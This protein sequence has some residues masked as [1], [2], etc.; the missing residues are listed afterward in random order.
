MPRGD[1]LRHGVQRDGDPVPLAG[2]ERSGFVVVTSPSRL[3]LDQAAYFHGRLRES[4]MPFVAF[5]AN[6]VH[7]EPGGG[8]ARRAAGRLDE[9]LVRA[10][11]EV[12]R[13]QQRLA[14][15]DARALARLEADTR[16]PLLQVPELEADVHD[17]RGLLTIGE[18]MLGQEPVSG[19][20]KRRAAAS[21]GR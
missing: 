15:H 10:L 12:Y 8:E 21:R 9:D 5:V 1:R 16:E 18:V 14:R 3:A 20:R 2:G 7:A 13:D 11:Q 17:L 6:R 4:G 19:V